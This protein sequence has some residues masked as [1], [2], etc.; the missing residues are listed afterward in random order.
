M[1]PQIASHARPRRSGLSVAGAFRLL[2]V[3]LFLAAGLAVVHHLGGVGGGPAGTA[4]PGSLN[5]AATPTFSIFAI[6]NL[7]PWPRP[8][9]PPPA[10]TPGGPLPIGVVA[11]HWGNDSGAVCDGWL[12]EVDIN[13]AI[14][15]RVV[16]TLRAL[17]YE[18]DLLQEFDPR[19]EG[20]RA[21]ALVSIH[22]D[23]CLYPEASGFKV[24][25]VE[26]SAVP[27]Q[28]D[29]LVSCLIDRYQARTGLEFHEGSITP[30]M[31]HYH[32]FYEID[33]RTPGAIIEVG[34]MLADR[35]LLL[36]EQDVVA[37][38]IV[39]GILCFVRDEGGE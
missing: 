9:E 39:E 15:E 24:A 8:T 18:V 10:A 28:E 35:E 4:A 25:R 1:T 13:L 5:G 20:Y 23:A 22:A 14:A 38:G 29:R 31:T 2:V 34:F 26:D 11:G 16:Y 32:T 7:N 21:Q 17:G 36:N 30:D 33:P 6:F 19:L 3:V 27:Q 12:R 37:Q